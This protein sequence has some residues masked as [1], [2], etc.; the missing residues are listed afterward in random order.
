MSKWTSFM[1]FIT[2]NWSRLESFCPKR[3]LLREAKEELATTKTLIFNSR[4]GPLFFL[5]SWSRP[6]KNCYDVITQPCRFFYDYLPDCLLSLRIH[7]QSQF[8][9]M[10]HSLNSHF[11]HT[12][13]GLSRFRYEYMPPF[14]EN[15]QLEPHFSFF[16]SW[17][18]PTW[19]GTCRFCYEI[20]ESSSYEFTIRATFSYDVTI[21]HAL[22]K[23]KSFEQN[24][25]RNIWW[26]LGVW[27]ADRP[28]PRPSR[29]PFVH[30][31]LYIFRPL[32]LL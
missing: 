12:W 28:L 10:L 16:H 30:Y 31:D 9:P 23:F 32:L 15:S 1:A 14:F 4:L 6:C 21:F 22:L 24:T 13:L 18:L 27:T 25:R 29:S 2:A 20:S 17:L 8:L 19:W 11:S 5:N 26:L 3:T 7:N